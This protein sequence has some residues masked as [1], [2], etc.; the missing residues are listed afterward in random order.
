MIESI[1]DIINDVLTRLERDVKIPNTQAAR[2]LVFE[3][4]MAESGYRNLEQIGGGPAISFWQIEI[5]TVEDIWENYVIYRKP[6]IESLF[7]MG[8]IEKDLTF[9]LITNIALAVAFCRLYY[10]RK[11]GAIP[12]SMPARAAYW[13]KWYNTGG[14]HGRGKGTVDHYIAANMP[15]NDPSEPA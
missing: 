7:R 2:K 1:K 8:L 12:K 6:Y 3:T 9:C 11:P 10:R 13:L 14:V 15:H 4:G 5:G